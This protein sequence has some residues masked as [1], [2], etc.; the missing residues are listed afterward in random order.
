[1]GRRTHTSNQKS[2]IVWV[3]TGALGDLLVG[4]ASLQ[5]VIWKW[6]HA[7]ITV[8]G[9][10][11]WLQILGAAN[12][13]QV[14]RILAIDRKSTR[15]QLYQRSNAPAASVNDARVPSKDHWTPTEHIS[16]YDELKRSDVLFNAR[17]DSVRQ[18]IPGWLARTPERWGSAPWPAHLI[19]NCRA[20][21]DGKDPLIHERDVPLLM[22]D[23]AEQGRSLGS[24]LAERIEH[25]PRIAH[26][27]KAGLPTLLSKS[28]KLRS[29]P[30]G[31]AGSGLFLMNPTASRVEKAW[32]ESRFAELIRHRRFQDWLKEHD[33]SLALIGAPNERDWLQRIADASSS[34]CR[35]ITP[36]SIG[37]LAGV[38]QSAAGLIAN[39]SSVQFI[40]ATCETPVA[41]LMGRARKE[42]WGPVGPNDIVIQSRNA[43]QFQQML[44]EQNIFELEAQ[45]YADID[46]EYVISSLEAWPA[47]T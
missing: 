9:S 18:G 14:D 1:M 2:R 47:F 45:A 19:Y 16:L 8:A 30:N 7:E 41:T 24:S 11:L 33:L 46:V 17:V 10:P 34:D 20:P 22:M 28:S 3:R 5:E 31:P 40:A 25:S 36:N 35:L 38:V 39:T 27:R 12:F 37:E 26:W 15:G 29:Q 6:P 44:A 4:L 21:H 32:P 13:H 43:S 23:E 42:I